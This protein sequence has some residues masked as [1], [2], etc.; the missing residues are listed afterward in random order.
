MTIEDMSTGVSRVRNRVI[1]RVFKELGYIEQW[2]SGIGRMLEALHQA[3][4]PAPLFEE[5][6]GR[7]RVTLWTGGSGRPLL[8]DDE[9]RLLNALTAAGTSGLS[10][11][12]LTEI[13]KRSVRTTR[14]RMRRLVELGLVF[15]IGSG[16][17]DPQRRY[18]AAKS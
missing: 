9:Q 17:T 15:Q 8:N 14:T 5:L 11:G 18:V 2:G 6:G 4:L 3:G 12:E 10:T 16:P 13:L 7:F 1:A